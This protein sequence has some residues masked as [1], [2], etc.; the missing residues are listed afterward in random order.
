LHQ[1]R[2]GVAPPPLDNQSNLDLM[3]LAGIAA[4]TRL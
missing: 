3:L 4:R 1:L 2:H